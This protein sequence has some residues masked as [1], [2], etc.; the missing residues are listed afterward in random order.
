MKIEIISKSHL[1]DKLNDW[2]IFTYS[3][4]TLQ[5]CRF[6]SRK[7]GSTRFNFKILAKVKKMHRK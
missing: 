4:V 5:C 2:N 1:A 3:N 7:S 6:V